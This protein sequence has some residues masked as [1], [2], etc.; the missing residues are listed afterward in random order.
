MGLPEVVVTPRNNLNLGETVNRGRNAAGN[1][2]KEILSAVTP[3]GD[4]ESAKGIYNDATSGNYGSAA[5]GLGLLALPNFIA[6]PLKAFKRVGSKV[7]RDFTNSRKLGIVSPQFKQ[8]SRFKSEL[9]WYYHKIIKV[10]GN[11]SKPANKLIEV[12]TIT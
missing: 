11:M 7:I 1:V 10:S 6:K 9:D 2:G 8:S 4:I 3:L 5:L 12:T